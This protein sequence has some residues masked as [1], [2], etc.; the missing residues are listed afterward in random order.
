MRP[1]A[2]DVVLKAIC[3]IVSILL[4]EQVEICQDNPGQVI[5]PFPAQLSS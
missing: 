4:S 2:F 1:L 3:Y 5:S